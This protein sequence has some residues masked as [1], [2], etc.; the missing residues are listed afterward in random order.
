MNGR[1]DAA[2]PEQEVA[3]PRTLEACA[4]PIAKGNCRA[5]KVRF[6]FNRDNSRCERFL[7]GARACLI[8]KTLS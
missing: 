7:Y 8:I 4:L 6:G 1:H 2:I 3:A 5:M